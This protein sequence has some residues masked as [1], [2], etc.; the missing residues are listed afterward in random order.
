MYLYAWKKKLQ[1]EIHSKKDVKGG[2]K[3]RV[4]QQIQDLHREAMQI[5]FKSIYQMSHLVWWFSYVFI[6][7]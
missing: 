3:M 7:S 6:D 2:L 1:K 5:H 4:E